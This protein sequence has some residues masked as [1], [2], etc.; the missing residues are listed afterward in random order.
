M[1]RLPHSPDTSTS[2]SGR[3]LRHSQA[4][5]AP[6]S[7]HDSLNK[8]L[9]LTGTRS[10]DVR[11][12]TLFWVSNNHVFTVFPV[13]WKAKNDRQML[14]F[15]N[16]FFFNAVICRPFCKSHTQHTNTP[17][18]I[19]LLSNSIRTHCFYTPP[20]LSLY[21]H[22]KHPSNIYTAFVD[23]KRVGSMKVNKWLIPLLQF[24]TLRLAL[25]WRPWKIPFDPHP[26]CKYSPELRDALNSD[27]AFTGN[28]HL[29]SGLAMSWL[30]CRRIRAA[31]HR[32]SVLVSLWLKG[33]RP[34]QGGGLQTQVRDGL[35]RLL[36]AN[37]S[38]FMKQAA[39]GV[40]HVYGAVKMI[41]IYLRQGSES[42]WSMAE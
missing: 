30:A 39:V 41:G 10:S 26:S 13:F 25:V 4:T 3:I 1:T 35:C 22:S 24:V 14:F 16:S 18:C 19:D 33:P 36:W 7:Q 2:S 42:L 23:D 38:W 9:F 15:L 40:L 8:S 11:V 12:L 31:A 20:K 37:K 29:Q 34:A 6:L 17:F 21:I 5:T 27:A 32:A 28:S